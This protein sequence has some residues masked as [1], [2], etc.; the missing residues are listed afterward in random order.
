MKH[1]THE[2][3][4]DMLVPVDTLVE[5]PDNPR[6]GNIDAIANSYEKFGQLKPIVV[7]DNGDGTSTVMSGKMRLPS[8]TSDIPIV[9]ILNGSIWLIFL[10]ANITSPRVGWSTPAMVL[11]K[12]DFPDPLAPMMATASPFLTSIETSHRTCRLS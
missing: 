3:L 8:G 11:S 9:T 2:S 5:L 1:N 4:H 6:R 12:V 7:K 10:P